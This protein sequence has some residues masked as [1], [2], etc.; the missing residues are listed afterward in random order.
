MKVLIFLIGL[1]LLISGIINLLT[2]IVLAI[3]QRPPF[4]GVV[5]IILGIIFILLGYYIICES[6]VSGIKELEH[7]KRKAEEDKAKETELRKQKFL[8]QEQWRQEMNNVKYCSQCG[9]VMEAKDNF[10]RSCGLIR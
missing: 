3:M 9:G 4:Y 2:G 10:C 8:E 6:D 7:K 5:G 1:G